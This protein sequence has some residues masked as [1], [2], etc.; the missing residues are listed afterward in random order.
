MDSQCVIYRKPLL[1]SGTLGTKGNV[2]VVVPDKTES[3]ASSADPPERGIPLC[4]LKYFPNRIEHTIQVRERQ[5]AN[6]IA[7]TLL[8]LTLVVVVVVV[9]A[10]RQWARDLFEG[11]FVQAAQSANA[12]IQKDNFE[13]LLRKNPIATQIDTLR[14]IESTLVTQSARNFEDVRLINGRRKETNRQR[15]LILLLFAVYRLGKVRVCRVVLEQ[16]SSVVVQLSL[17]YGYQQWRYAK[18]VV[19]CVCVC[20]CV[21]VFC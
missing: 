17:G 2:Q 13:E 9:V 6:G 1:E 14:S 12:Y 3:Y 21:C 10:T 8:T 15:E 11:L 5:A 4:T 19:V 18:R 20:V 16:H 7:S